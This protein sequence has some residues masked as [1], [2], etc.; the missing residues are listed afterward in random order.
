MRLPIPPIL[1]LALLLLPLPGFGPVARA[2]SAPAPSAPAPSVPAQPPA[3]PAVAPAEMQRLLALL[4]DEARRQELIRTLEALSAVAPAQP[5]EAAP[6]AA[7]SP[8]VTPPAATPPVEAPPA[9]AAAAAVEQLLAPDTLGGQLLQ[10]L[11]RR[12]RWLSEQVVS[13]VQTVTDLPSLISWFSALAYDPVTRARVA[14]ASWKLAL[15]FGLGLLAEM[16]ARRAT[17]RPLRAL[18]ARAPAPRPK[19]PDLLRRL[20][21][22][23]GRLLLDLAPVAAFAL[24]SYGLIGA[25]RPLP[26]TQ[27]VL[28]IANNAYI[29][30]R[31]LGVLSRLALA[32]A[33]PG[34]RPLPVSDET[35][36]YVDLW[37]RRLWVI[38]VCGYALAEAGL[39]FGLPWG[40]YDAIQRLSHLVISI[41]LGVM[42][43]QNRVAVA[44]VLRAPPLR[45]G[46]RPHRAR[47]AARRF[48]DGLAEIWHILAIL[49]LL[50][51]WAVWALQI[52]HGLYRLLRASLLTLLVLGG[53]RGLDLLLRR[54]L[55]GSLRAAP[56]LT[57]RYPA[58]ESRANRYM[59]LAKGAI[60]AGL[61]LLVLMM[62]MEVWGIESFSWFA[63][64]ALGNRV[65][66]SLA[67]VG[68]TALMAA[69]VWEAVNLAIERHLERLSRDADAA[70]SARVRTLMPMLRTTLLVVILLFVAFNLLTELGVNVAP[71][72]AGAGVI[73]LAL[74]FGSQK[75]VQDVITGIFLLFEDA[76]AVGDVVDLGGKSGVV[77]Q[78]S[79]RSIKLRA[80]DGSL[81]IIPFSA[82]NGVT[83]MTRDFSFALLDVQVAYKEDTDRVVEALQGLC[84]EMR[85]EA[86]WGLVI[87]DAME[88]LGV[89]QL[90]PDGPVIRVRIKTEPL[91]RWNVMR[92]MNRRIKRRFDELGI[93][94]PAHRQK[95]MME[96]GGAFPPPPGRPA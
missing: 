46:D 1:L 38:L 26:T 31:L 56:D 93:E 66:R 89:N 60:S 51:V 45:P 25:V 33:V 67:S 75:L 5:G 83:N 22:V 65:L 41:A 16:L 88:V 53:A 63:P 47:A 18:E 61:T 70:R 27:L 15:L 74:G 71:L 7:A 64:G 90:S 73:G 58:L 77:E 92:E 80:L 24:L 2:Q 9:N 42:V 81:H 19:L 20:P 96:P 52:E 95:L 10:G 85:S 39:L 76:M 49:Y 40:A 94:I 82:V 8:A 59:P 35:A 91:E 43:L 28:L 3:S 12:L 78:L 37:L 87:R 14:D 29:A 54:A 6:P 17:A 86:K 32:P 44:R 50:A 69:L 21:L 79:I 48:R 68:F 36:A 57:G 72:L 23:L 55:S 34:L 13:G 11:S 62:L 4:R 30:C 84:Q